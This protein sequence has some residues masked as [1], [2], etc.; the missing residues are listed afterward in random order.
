MN[1]VEKFPSSIFID[2]TQRGVKGIDQV[3]MPVPQVDPHI[4]PEICYLVFG[5]Q[6]GC[7]VI[8]RDYERNLQQ[9]RIGTTY[10]AEIA[11]T[12]MNLT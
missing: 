6:V 2:D 7:S 10:V 1:V 8:Y 11:H 3:P 12:L 9:R 4:L 5:L